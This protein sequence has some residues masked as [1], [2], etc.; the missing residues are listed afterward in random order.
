MR[1]SSRVS[2]SKGAAPLC[3]EAR[4]RQVIVFTHDV[5]FLLALDA[6]A[7]H[8]EREIVH[9]HIRRGAAG[10]GLCVAELPWVAKKVK[11]RISFLKAELQRVG[12]LEREGDADGYHDGASHFYGLL[13]ETW[14]RCVEEVLV[15]GVV[16][17]YRQNIQTGQIRRLATVTDQDCLEVEAG[18]T[19]SSR[20]LPGHDQAPAENAELP[21]VA[22]LESDLNALDALVKRV[23]AARR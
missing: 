5:V 15:G 6:A 21:R 17:R 16:E 22:E 8:R 19:K 2:R 20:W 1:E 9:Q 14:E 4:T 11:E 12:R 18:M 7:K 10:A 13:R 3:D 23:N